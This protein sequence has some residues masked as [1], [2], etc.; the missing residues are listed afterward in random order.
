MGRESVSHF[1]PRT[2]ALSGAGGGQLTWSGGAG[3]SLRRQG[4][5]YGRLAQPGSVLPRPGPGLRRLP[6]LSS[7]CPQ[8]PV[9]SGCSQGQQR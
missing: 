9:M 4:S 7:R 2:A 3:S 6:E 1:P 8:P 5:R